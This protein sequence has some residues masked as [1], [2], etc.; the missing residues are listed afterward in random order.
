MNTILTKKQSHLESRLKNRLAAPAILP[1][2]MALQKVVNQI[3]LKPELVELVKLRASQINRCAF[4]IDM[5]FRDA[6]A[7]GESTER[8]YLLDAWQEVDVYS[9]RERAA[10]AWTEARGCQTQRCPM[11]SSRRRAPI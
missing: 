9:P 4:C 10:L 8:L 3:S 6:Q 5:H 7:Q 11:K 2:M 1:A